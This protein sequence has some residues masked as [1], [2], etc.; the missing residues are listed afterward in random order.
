MIVSDCSRRELARQSRNTW[1]SLPDRFRYTPECWNLGLQ[2]SVII[3]LTD[4]RLKV[5]S[6]D[7]N[8]HKL[9]ERYDP[10]DSARQAL[11]SIA[12]EIVT[13]ILQLGNAQH[14]AVFVNQDFRY[15]VGSACCCLQNQL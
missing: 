7:L 11:L 5:L 4:I 13:I 12:G 3:A 10:T 15:L 9:M 14:R 2:P 6:N 1:E 8:I